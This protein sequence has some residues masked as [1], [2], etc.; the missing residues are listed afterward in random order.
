[1]KGMEVYRIR[2]QTFGQ[3]IAATFRKV[4]GLDLEQEKLDAVCAEMFDEKEDN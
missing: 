2:R 1:M 3:R 4:F